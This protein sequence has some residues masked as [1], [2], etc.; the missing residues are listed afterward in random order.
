MNESTKKETVRMTIEKTVPIIQ[1]Y[2]QETSL[3]GDDQINSTCM[4]TTLH[5]HMQ[6]A[7]D[8]IHAT[9]AFGFTEQGKN[10]VV[11][12]SIGTGKIHLAHAI[13]K[14]A[15]QRRPR[16]LREVPRPEGAVAR[17][18]GEGRRRGEVHAQVRRLPGPRAERTGA[19]QARRTVSNLPARAHG[20]TLRPHVDRVL[21]AVQAEGPACQA[22]RRRPRRRDHGPYSPRRRLDQ[23]RGDEHEEEAGAPLRGAGGPV[24]SKRRK[25]PYP[26][27]ATIPPHYWSRTSTALSK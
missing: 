17:V 2:N 11:Q 23:H 26:F 18:E 14:A 27:R 7:V 24:V 1:S 8:K 15:C 6:A 13:A 21:H 19:R 9:A 25:D 20:G 22:R 12:D 16:A 10:L 3:Q 4:E 5:R